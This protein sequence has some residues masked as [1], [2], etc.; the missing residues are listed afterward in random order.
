[1]PVRS[2]SAAGNWPAA[3][4]A[5]LRRAAAGRHGG[6]QLN[7]PTVAAAALTTGPAERRSGPGGTPSPESERTGDK[8]CTS[9]CPSATPPRAAEDG[10][11]RHHDKRELKVVR[12]DLPVGESKRLENGDLFPL[13]RQQAREHRVGHERR[14]TQKDQRKANGQACAGCGFRPTPGCG[15]DDRPGRTR[16]GRH[17][18]LEVWSSAAMNGPLWQ[19]R[20]PA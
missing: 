2:S 7:T 8:A 6:P 14:H 11:R 10:S 4:A 17:T 20:D 13:Q 16:R 9:R 19:A 1:M 15:R 3:P 18:A 12:D 5:S